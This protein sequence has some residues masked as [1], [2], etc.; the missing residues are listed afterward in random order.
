MVM[1]TLPNEV[2]SVYCQSWCAQSQTPSLLRRPV[3]YLIAVEKT[4]LGDYSANAVEE[5]DNPSKPTEMHNWRLIQPKH[6]NRMYILSCS[7][8]SSVYII[9][10]LFAL[11][12]VTTGSPS[13]N[14]IEHNHVWCTISRC[15]LESHLIGHRIEELAGLT[16]QPTPC[17]SIGMQIHI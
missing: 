2:T 4:L 1:I 5:A 14:A 6:S 3:K 16:S 17:F 13:T 9:K 7:G 11:R 10:L 12:S 8:P 15:P